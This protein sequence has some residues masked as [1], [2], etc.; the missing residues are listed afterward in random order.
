[1]INGRKCET[2]LKEIRIHAEHG[3][4]TGTRG[5]CTFIRMKNKKTVNLYYY[6]PLHTDASVGHSFPRDQHAS[7]SER[8]SVP[9]IREVGHSA[10]LTPSRRQRG[11]PQWASTR[12]CPSK[13][14]SPRRR[15]SSRSMAECHSAAAVA[16]PLP[17]LQF[18]GDRI[19]SVRTQIYS[20]EFNNASVPRVQGAGG[21]GM[22]TA[23]QNPTASPTKR[24]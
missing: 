22:T 5:K 4:E 16:P 6:I 8:R 3:V 13:R 11:E 7:C 19:W 14:H 20:M 9:P 15:C 24:P 2:V 18:S 10:P 12:L 23:I 17:L 1:M 21:D